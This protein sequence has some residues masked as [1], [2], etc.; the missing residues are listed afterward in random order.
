MT[1]RAW[2]EVT[3]DRSVGTS[4]PC[5]PPTIVTI[6]Y[7][8]A[9]AAGLVV[10]RHAMDVLE[11]SGNYPQPFGRYG[12]DLF[13]VI[14]GY[15][16][17]TTTAERG[18]SP[19]AF[20]SARIVRIVPIYWIYT[21][22]FIALA[23]VLPRTLLGPPVDPI[24][25]L[26]SYFFI[27]AEHPRLGAILPIYTIGW[28]LNYEMFFYFIFG[29]CLF[30]PHRL[31]R[32]AVV[33]GTLLLLVLIGWRL[34]SQSAVVTIYTNPILLQFA[35][36]IVLA[37]ASSR[38]QRIAPVVG[39][40]LLAAVS[41]WLLVVYTGETLPNSFLAYRLPAIVTVAGA[42]ILEPVAR[43]RPS[44]LSLLLGDASYSI[45]LAHPFAVRAWYFAFSYAFGIVGS[46]GQAV[47]VVTSMMAGI[48]GGIVSFL[49]L[50]RPIL[51]AARCRLLGGRAEV[52]KR[53]SLI[54]SA[55]SKP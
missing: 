21:T 4:S 47:F 22:L 39:W 24:H 49:L 25:I 1:D 33:V 43:A 31:F 53:R 46:T 42:L 52:E 23:F 3:E 8:R 37:L 27:P 16:M 6:Q 15:I 45:Y 20:W 51:A 28:T 29:C 54:G 44:R 5:P 2:G 34:P 48:A 30:I 13:F 50:E 36:G 17:W 19:L 10:L 35:A 38:L 12:V 32:F 9:I 55:L 26:Q 40:G 7:L 11:L 14:S 18:R 41:V